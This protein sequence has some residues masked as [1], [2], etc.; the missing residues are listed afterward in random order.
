MT[1]ELD[2]LIVKCSLIRAQR[3]VEVLCLDVLV[4]RWF[5]VDVTLAVLDQFLYCR[6]SHEVANISGSEDFLVDVAD[7]VI[8]E[9][10][11]VGF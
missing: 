9:H 5:V 10:R 4:L 1:P 8:D 2:W 7:A 6:S 3:A 11:D